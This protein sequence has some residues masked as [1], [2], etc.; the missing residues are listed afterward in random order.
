MKKL[1]YVG[2]LLLISAV[3]LAS[4][5]APSPA[6][7]PTK[8]VRILVGFPPGGG[9]DAMTRY[10]GQKMGESL[11]HNFVV[12]N[13]PGAS[14]TIATDLVAKAPPDG[15]TLLG[16]SITHVLNASMFDKL[17]FDPVKDFAPISTM[18]LNVDVIA[19]HPS[20][21]A[22]TLRD[23]VMLAKGSPGQISYAHA[24]SGTMM[25]VGMELFR[26]MAGIQLLA[27]P[28]NGAGPSTIAVLGGQVPV[29]STSL[30][31]ALPH[32]KVGKLRM[33]AVTSAQR[34]P[35]APEYPTVAEAAKLPGYEAIVWI[36][37]LAPAGT[38]PAIVN[39]L[40]AE[41]ERLVRQPEV[42]E[43]LA[44]QA[45][46]PLRQSPQAFADMIRTDVVKWGKVIRAS[47]AKAE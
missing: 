23:L 19:V 31:A 16:A 35:L 9:V 36:G 13:R 26:A 17:P 7:Y 32:A 21:P 27:V 25:F 1:H 38:P 44:R 34:T 28:Y 24:G 20:M 5:Q 2:A 39:K 45:N 42:R 43:Q 18:A 41:I 30:L 6:A 14:G 8:P 40:N 4:A 3:S 29:L 12:E 46:E 15:Y 10:F 11:G 47:G 22:R 37:L 33:L